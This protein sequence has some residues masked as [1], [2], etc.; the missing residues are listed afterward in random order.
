MTATILAWIALGCLAAVAT[1]LAMILAA[2]RNAHRPLR[3][4]DAQAAGA[5]EGAW[6][7]H[8]RSATK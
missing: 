1:L 4:D 7:F 2:S 3:D 6:G 8:D 5:E